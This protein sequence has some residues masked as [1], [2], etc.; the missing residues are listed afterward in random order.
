MTGKRRLILMSRTD[1]TG[2]YLEERARQKELRRARRQAQT[3]QL[4]GLLNYRGA[5][6]QVT[7]ALGRDRG[8]GRAAVYRSG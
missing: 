8:S 2:V 4:T 6:N 1:V 5:L 3:D 7:D